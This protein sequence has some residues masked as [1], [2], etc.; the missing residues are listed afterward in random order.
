MTVV[1]ASRADLTLDAV[2]AVAWQ[3]EPVALAP[4]V[5]ERM[6]QAHAAFQAYLA[7]RLA[8]DPV[9]L[10]YGVTTGPGDTGDALLSEQAQATRPRGLWTA[11]SFGEPLPARVVRAIVLA[12][13]ANLVDGYAGVRPDLADAVAALLDGGPL[14]A[15]PARG[16]GG[17]GEILA[18]G[19][20]FAPLADGLELEPRE[21][22]ALIN[23]SPCAAALVADAALAGRGRLELAERTFALSAEAI[24]APTDAFDPDLGALWGDPHESAALTSLTALLA[25]GAPDRQLHQGPVSYRVLPRVLGRTREAQAHA[26]ATAASALSAVTDN[27]VFL[28]PSAARPLGALVSNGGYHNDRAHPALDGLAHAWADLAQLAQRHVD[29]LFQHPLTG[30]ALSGEWKAK[31]LHMVA[32]GYAEDARTLAQTTVLGLGAFGQNDL[33]AP[34]FLAWGKAVAVGTCLDRTLAVLA[35]LASEALQDAGQ[36][37]PP[38]LAPFLDAIRAAFPPIEAPRPLGPDAEAPGRGVRA[39]G[40]PVTGSGA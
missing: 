12:R 24:R 6:E 31:P 23:G 26:E 30:P 7:D 37:A 19:H 39:P 5:A 35:A 14:P 11:A 20:L 15:V 1:V 29:K 34:A 40:P 10:L 18:L 32:A 36:P 21:K 13:L 16:N 28:L 8:T 2:R 38:A 4:V 3:G 17:S 22:M 33:P 9:A 25:G 27:P